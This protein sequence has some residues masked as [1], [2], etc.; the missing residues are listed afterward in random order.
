MSNANVHTH[1][2]LPMLLVGGAGGKLKAGS[3]IRYPDGTPMTNLFLT[4]L[5][6]LDVPLDKLGDSTGKLNL[7]SV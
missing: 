5:D 7:L 6:K 2:N 4:V 3:H 1:T